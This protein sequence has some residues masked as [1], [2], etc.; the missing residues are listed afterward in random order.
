KQRVGAVQALFRLKAVIDLGP[1]AHRDDAVAAYGDGSVL[2]D[3]PLRSH[4]E[5]KTSAPDPIRRLRGQR[6]C[7]PKQA[8]E[9][10]HRTAL[11]T[12]LS[13]GTFRSCHAG[14]PA[15]VPRHRKT[16]TGSAGRRRRVE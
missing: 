14:S 6:Q 11:E 4:R 16:P 5:D 8:T 3:A 10:T 15:S 13:V 7:G 12:D 1:A 2:D 9:K